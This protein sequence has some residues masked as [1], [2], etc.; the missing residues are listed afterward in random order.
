MWWWS[1]DSEEIS[2]GAL[3]IFSGYL[4]SSLWGKETSQGRVE[5]DVTSSRRGRNTASI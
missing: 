1:R 5:R 3:C 4:K 2:R